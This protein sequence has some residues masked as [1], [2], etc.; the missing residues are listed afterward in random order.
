LPYK[1]EL[2]KNLFNNADVIVFTGGFNKRCIRNDISYA[3]AHDKDLF[4]VGTKHFGYNLNWLIRLNPASRAGQK[5]P[6]PVD[7]INLEQEWSSDVPAENYISLLGP[8]VK[9]GLVPIT[10]ELGRMLSTDRAHV[11]KYGAKFFGEHALR[12]SVYG[13]LLL[14]RAPS[15][16]PVAYA[17]PR[18][19]SK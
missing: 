10:D 1:N 5:N 6:L 19:S 11:T 8:V 18:I 7:V 17:V 12:N 3:G 2:S 16:L 13:D 14:A 4:Y 15:A 9:D